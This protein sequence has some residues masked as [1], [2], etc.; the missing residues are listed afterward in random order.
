[1]I[2]WTVK[3]EKSAEKSVLFCGLLKLR[4][5]SDHRGLAVPQV[6]AP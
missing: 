3:N 5:A 2:I 6:I 4:L 1:M